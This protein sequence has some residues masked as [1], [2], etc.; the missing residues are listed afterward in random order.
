MKLVYEL[1]TKARV[2]KLLLSLCLTRAQIELNPLD[3]IACQNIKLG[4]T[5]ENIVDEFLSTFS[6]EYVH[7]FS[8]TRTV[9]SAT[10]I[11]HEPIREMQYQLLRQEFWTADTQQGLRT[12]IEQSNDQTSHY[13]PAMAAVFDG[14]ILG[15]QA[16]E[17]AEVITP[18]SFHI[19][20]DPLDRSINWI[21]QTFTAA[22]ALR[23]M[24]QEVRVFRKF[25]AGLW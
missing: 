23:N 9:N 24:S 25:S 10:N 11:R 6:A 5:S 8:R 17:T 20:P 7:P 18:S 3:D 1:A 13:G 16:E 21:F 15:E 12:K 22:P 4:M 2:L 14:L 19:E